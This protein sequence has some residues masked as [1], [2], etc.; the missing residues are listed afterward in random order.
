MPKIENLKFNSDGL[1][2]AIAQDVENGQVLMMA[3]MNKE[4]LELTISTGIMHYW[5]RSRNALW[6][7]GAT[8][9]H[10]QTVIELFYDCDGDT[11]L[12]IV[13]QIGAACHTGERSCFFSSLLDS[14]T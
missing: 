11:I 4:S 9:G 12:A 14:D 7:K 5:S 10:E 1:I 6:R 3:W 13:K 8:S 2:P